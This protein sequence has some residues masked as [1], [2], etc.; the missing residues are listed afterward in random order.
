VVVTPHFSYDTL[1]LPQ[2]R[3]SPTEWSAFS[4]RYADC[5]AFLKAEA[6]LLF[7]PAQP[8]QF[9]AFLVRNRADW[10]AVLEDLHA[11]YREPACVLTGQYA[12]DAH[13]MM[14]GALDDLDTSGR[15][16]YTPPKGRSRGFLG[17]SDGPSTFCDNRH[18]RFPLGCPYGKPEEPLVT[19]E[20]LVGIAESIV[21]HPHANPAGAGGGSAKSARRAK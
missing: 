9:L 12:Y 14:A 16:M 19:A 17:R 6:R 4:K 1:F 3:L 10:G 18:W 2:F 21:R 13:A 15:L 7:H 8:D 5:A 11:K 20:F